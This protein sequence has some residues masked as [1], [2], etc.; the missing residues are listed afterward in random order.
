M[1]PLVLDG[2]NLRLNQRGFQLE[3]ST[4]A[5]NRVFAP[6]ASDFDSKRR[7]LKDYVVKKASSEEAQSESEEE[8][9]ATEKAEA[10]SQQI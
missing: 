10:K 8:T 5:S 7:R 2:Y 1:N 6:Y 3:V 4:R 9:L